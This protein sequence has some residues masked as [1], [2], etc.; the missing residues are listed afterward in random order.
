MTNLNSRNVII[1]QNLYHI[2]IANSAVR[3]IMRVKEIPMRAIIDTEANV[4][5]ITL[6]VVK[7]L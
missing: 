6:P 2:N 7:K 5:I 1:Q 4:F 3:T